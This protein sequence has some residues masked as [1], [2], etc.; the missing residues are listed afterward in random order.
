MAVKELKYAALLDCY[1]KLLSPKQ[2]DAAE[3][4]YCDDL[5]LAEIAEHMGVT[6][7]GVRDQIRHAQEIMDGAEANLHIYEK[8]TRLRGI[9]NEIAKAAQTTDAALTVAALCEQ[10]VAVL[11]AEETE[12]DQS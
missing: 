11:D 12:A 2:R 8:E 3:Y 6:R 5:S 7:Q 1:A 4:Y 9:L 10:A